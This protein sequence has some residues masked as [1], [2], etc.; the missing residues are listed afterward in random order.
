MVVQICYY[1]DRRKADRLV[2]YCVERDAVHASV[3]EWGHRVDRATAGLA[4]RVDGGE[5]RWAALAETDSQSANCGVEPGMGHEGSA[6]GEG[7]GREQMAG[8]GGDAEKEK[9]RGGLA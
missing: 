1:G 3:H 5:R 9:S 2:V 4:S 7:T 8:G 6:E